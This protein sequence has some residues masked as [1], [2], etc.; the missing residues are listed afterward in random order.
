MNWNRKY[1]LVGRV[2]I[3]SNDRAQQQQWMGRDCFFFASMVTR[4]VY[5][6]YLTNCKQPVLTTT[7]EVIEKSVPRLPRSCLSSFTT[8]GISFH[9][10]RY[11]IP[12]L[13]IFNSG[14]HDFE[15]IDIA[16]PSLIDNGHTNLH[17]YRFFFLFE[18]FE[19]R[20]QIC[21]IRESTSS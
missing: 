7:M 8:R 12:D 1:L 19:H 2:C 15:T 4:Y 21:T 11:W 20:I 6:G 14:S 18:I 9:Q 3:L 5:P 17:T 10:W 13:S 16:V